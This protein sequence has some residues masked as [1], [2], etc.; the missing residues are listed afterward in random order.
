MK[1]MVIIFAAL[2]M[3]P[4]FAASLTPEQ[5][6]LNEIVDAEAKKLP[7]TAIEAAEKLEKMTKSSNQKGLYVRAIAAK[8]TN[9]SHHLGKNPRDKVKILKDEIGKTP[10]EVRPILKT[11]LAVWFWQYYNQN[12]FKFSARTRTEGLDSDDFTTWDLPKIFAE[13]SSFFEDAL[14]NSDS[15]KKVTIT[16]YKGA[17]SAGTLWPRYP[18]TLYEFIVREALNFYVAE[19]SSLPSSEDEF[20][21]ESSSD[22]FATYSI[23]LKYKPATTDKE[24]AS[25]RAIQLHQELMEFYLK[26]KLT[27]QFID[28]DLQRLMFVMAHSVGVEKGDIFIK[29]LKEIEQEF[30]ENETSTLASYAIAE[31][32]RSDKK[33]V[34]AE[35]TCQRAVLLY[36]K[37]DGAKL[38]HNIINGIR[39]G[40]FDLKTESHIDS[41]NSLLFLKYKNITRLYFKVVEDDWLE[42]MQTTYLGMDGINE[43][44]LKALLAKRPVKE[45]S[46][47]LEETKDFDFKDIETPIPALPYGFYRIIASSE[48]DFPLN[49]RSD[50]NKSVLSHVSFWVTDTTLL[51]KPGTNSVLGLAVDS[52]TGEPLGGR[53]IRVLQGDDSDN[54][55][56]KQSKMID[57]GSDGRFTQ[58]LSKKNSGMNFIFVAESETGNVAWNENYFHGLSLA[59]KRI[60]YRSVL[61]TDRAIYRPGQRIYFKGIC[62]DTNE[63]TEKY[64]VAECKNV[65]LILY[66]NNGREISKTT[67]SANTFGSFSG[68]FL[69]P[70]NVLAGEMTIRAAGK[71]SSYVAFSVEEYKRPKFEVTLNLP[72]KEFALGGKVIV[73]GNASS[74]AGAPIAGSQ[75]RYRVK[76]LVQLPWWWRW[77]SPSSTDQ[78]IAHGRTKTSESGE[79]SV[80]FPAIPDK[81]INAKIKPIFT[82]LIDVDVIDSTGETRSASQKVN[83][84]YVSLKARLNVSEWLPEGKD[85]KVDITTQSLDERPVNNEGV[86]EIYS[87]EG[88]AIPHRRISNPEYYFRWWDASDAKD[89]KNI[90]KD[91][92]DIANWNVGKKI[93]EAPYKTKDGVGS[94]SFKGKEGAWRAILKTKDRFQNP[95]EEQIDF[96]VFSKNTK[97][98]KAKV[99]SFLKIKNTSVETGTKFEAV[100]ATGYEKAQAYVSI[101]RYGKELKS[102][103]TKKGELKHFIDMPVTED[104]KGGFTLQVTFVF[105]NQVWIYNKFITVL[106]P[107]KDIKISMETFRSK[108]RPGEKDTWSLKIQGSKAEK[109]AAEMVATL[110]D[111]SLESFRPH[112]WQNF[113]NAFWTD[114]AARP[115]D[116]NFELKTFKMSRSTSS[117]SEGA[118]RTYPRF[119]NVITNAFG[120][121]ILFDELVNA[122][123]SK[124]SAMMMIDAEFAPGAGEKGD[125]SGQQDTLEVKGIK[126]IEAK[127]AEPTVRKNLNETAFFYPH[128]LSNKKG[129]V[130]IEFTMPEALTRWKFLGMA[131]GKKLE[132]GNITQEIVTQQELM[133]TPN[134]PRFLRQGDKLSF[135][136]KIDNLSGE[137]LQGN[138]VLELA[139]ALDDT[140][141]SKDFI[142]SERTLK[143]SIGQKKSAAFTWDI[144]VPDVTFPLIYRVKASTSKFS[145]GEEGLL[146]VLSRTILVKESMPL[147]ISGPGESLFKFEKLLNSKNSKTIKNEKLV[148]QVVSNPSWYA[149]Q[150]L[151]WLSESRCECTDQIFNRL[152]ANS[153]G[154]LIVDS[155]PKIEKIFSEWK[156]TDALKS[157]LQKGQD[158]KDVL[159]EETPWVR[160]AASEEKAKNNVGKFFEKVTLK[161]NLSSTWWE[162]EERMLPS[163]GWPWFP[164]G[165]RDNFITLY[166]VTG[167]GKLRQLGVKM[168]VDL[169]TKSVEGIDRWIKELYDSI[170]PADRDKDHYSSLVAYYL[171]GRSFFLK[172]VPI[173]PRNKEA[174]DYYLAQA[175][176]YWTSLDSKMSEAHT[177]LGTA[178][179]G[180]PKPAEE[181]IKSLRER[182]LH[183]KEMGMYWAD[184]EWSYW[185]YRAPIETQ[186]LMIELFKEIAKNETEVDELNVWLLKQKQTQDWKTNKA[187]TEAVYA[188]LLG[189]R[190]LLSSDKLVTATLGDL[191]IEPGKIEAGTGFYEKRFAAGEIKAAMG[192]VKLAKTDKGIA[193]GG[194]HWQYFEDI[195]QITP[196]KT[197]L[198]L[199]KR[200]FVK[201]DSKNG[202]VI[203]PY[204]KGKLNVGDSLVVRIELRSDRDMEYVHMKDMRGSGTEPVNVLS[205]WKYQD[206]LAYYESTKD[207]ATNFF[208]PYLPKGTYVFEYDLKIFHKGSYQT[209]M[210]QAQSMYAPEFSAHSESFGLEVE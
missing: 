77:K 204:I 124:S 143:F 83:L 84:G 209:G 63:V 135:S 28:S 10:E 45:W 121:L 52:K 20:E 146:P 97:E 113:T 193:W 133:V 120:R 152:Y 184:E 38:C 190:D 183:S 154:E 150:A 207:I 118:N 116:S 82:Y 79:F 70:S 145:D 125:F 144:I 59:Q 71:Y 88:P 165:K 78:E 181:I 86:I 199:V 65:D 43:D 198:S 196:H 23:F 66:D 159:L 205:N 208:F 62:Y 102:Y 206:G 29:R 105:A 55:T 12:R 115:F 136:A 17:I 203:T 129:V 170:T 74:Y 148:L 53:K 178:R 41:L 210:V 168:N 169:A 89:D 119:E 14:K 64:Q 175:A 34:D 202:Q 54:M 36:P 15:L 21:I 93:F 177:A 72:D 49:P 46:I 22:A 87:L 19:I 56:F 5:K 2:L 98:F 31:Q 160:D 194:L 147:W 91:L 95:V 172:D 187:T 109:I 122:V 189:G 161:N 180:N 166:I 90:K 81:T 186:A 188:L 191:K 8:I 138:I 182:A 100:W 197:P 39:H 47:D 151:P 142:S 126:P 137:E 73:T 33:L 114:S 130:K 167:F 3:L 123:F 101:I 67:K 153:L 6:L 7:Q 99:P 164:G 68:D 16:E 103:W 201:G 32:Y 141:V 173:Q 1:T 104:L 75:V 26:E 9:K 35:G 76:R 134:P 42:R 37:S 200:L 112:S 139:N 57:V 94:V 127:K 40:D 110:Y 149:V 111:A 13:I 58:P 106:R 163:G 107:E 11:I 18:G 60:Y 176:K 157:N 25:L 85:V 128:L 132:S 179:F 69:V 48:K 195:S 192:E 96:I 117:A 30:K 185:W 51:I 156:G 158:L 50:M 131:H 24:S 155:N 108:L 61:F 44:V 171:Y 174:I 80:E 140:D 4:V 92:S 27:D 162:L